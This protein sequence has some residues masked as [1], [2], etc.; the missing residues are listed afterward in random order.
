MLSLLSLLSACDSHAGSDSGAPSTD[1]DTDTVDLS[2][3]DPD[4]LPQG[5]SPCRQPELVF[6][7]A[8]IDGDTIHVD[9]SR[10]EES[11][12]MIGLD[13]PEVG[14]NGDSS[15]CYGL[16]AQAYTRDALE[17][18]EVWLTFDNNCTDMYDRTLAYVHV[19]SG[20]Q[21]FFQ[22]QLLRGGYGRAYPWEDTATF[23]DT[24]AQ[25]ELHA[26]SEG[27]GL[28]GLCD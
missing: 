8:A 23:E 16:E 15:E 18:G 20:Q 26:Q 14:W 25:D 27:L 10:G 3:I 1:T 4:S 12:R 6:V 13:T 2:T 28:W 24:F 7:Y 19:G 11:I 21:D 22:R 17:D 9:S 5:S